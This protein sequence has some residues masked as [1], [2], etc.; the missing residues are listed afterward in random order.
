MPV[1]TELE[2]DINER[3]EITDKIT[4]DGT[5]R[6]AAIDISNWSLK[7]VIHAVGAAITDPPLLVYTTAANQ[8]TIPVGS[9]GVL[10]FTIP[11]AD[12]QSIGV[13]DFQY[14]ISRVDP[15]SEANLTKGPFTIKYT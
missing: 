3:A 1:I 2:F 8:I 7:A 4:V 10:V 9:D 15:G 12:V 6:G 14:Y 13:G 5:K 11:L